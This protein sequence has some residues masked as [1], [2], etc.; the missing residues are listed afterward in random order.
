MTKLEIIRNKA[1]T[2]L[3]LKNAYVKLKRIAA[4]KENW[5]LMDE[6][7]N[8]AF[9]YTSKA[10]AYNDCLELF[11]ENAEETDEISSIIFKD[12]MKRLYK[13]EK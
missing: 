6:Y 13:Q 2:S 5:K 3:T 10:K 11:G 7:S 1:H 9:T 12:E 4:G 8:M